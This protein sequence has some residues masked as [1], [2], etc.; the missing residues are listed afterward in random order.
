MAEKNQNSMRKE[1]MKRKKSRTQNQEIMLECK[2]FVLNTDM[3][4]CHSCHN[5]NK[6]TT[7]SGKCSSFVDA[8]DCINHVSFS[9]TKFK[10]SISLLWQS[11]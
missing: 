4:I 2:L 7:S 5:N 11:V 3:L 9:Q 8:L 6:P 10:F 1:N